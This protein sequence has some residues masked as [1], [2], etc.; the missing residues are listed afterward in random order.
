M[1]GGSLDPPP[2]FKKK[3]NGPAGKPASFRI[4]SVDFTSEFIPEFCSICNSD[5]ILVSNLLTLPLTRPQHATVLVQL[6]T[7]MA[8]CDDMVRCSKVSV[9]GYT[10]RH[11]APVV[12][13]G[14]DYEHR[15]LYEG[16]CHFHMSQN[17]AATGL[18]TIWPDTGGHCNSAP[19]H[20]LLLMH[21]NR[22]GQHVLP[23]AHSKQPHCAGGLNG[24]IQEL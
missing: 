16:G 24:S 1:G 20:L 10:S 6:L 8:V 9:R 23:H 17:S 18:P 3:K 5:P 13:Q 4:E 12:H 7:Y 2:P 21:C 15:S 14:R 11:P 22:T 19:H